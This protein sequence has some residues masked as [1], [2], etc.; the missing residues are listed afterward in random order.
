MLV[1]FWLHFG[2]TLVA[3]WLHFG[4]ILVTLWLHFGNGKPEF[5]SWQT[6][7]C[8]LAN[9]HLR[10]HLANRQTCIFY[11]YIYIY[12]FGYQFIYVWIPNY[13]FLETHLY[14]FGYPF[15]HIGYP[16]KS[17][18]LWIPIYAISIFQIFYFLIGLIT[19]VGDTLNGIFDPC[20]WYPK[21]SFLTFISF[22]R[23]CYS[24]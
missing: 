7:V 3:F 23:P 16:N 12:I 19:R 11:I 8:Q 5:A 20:V 18:Y 13:I 17:E 24:N 9:L 22:A 10:G 15:M 1:T 4:Y 21:S 14:M 2:Y 6:L